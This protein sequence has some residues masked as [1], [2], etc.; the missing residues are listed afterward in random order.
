MNSE[1]IRTHLKVV[2]WINIVVGILFVLSAISFASYVFFI[3]PHDGKNSPDGLGWGSLIA[4]FGL[5]CSPLGLLPILTGRYLLQYRLWTHTASIILSALY[6]LSGYLII[7]G[8]YNL[9][10]LL[11]PE[12]KY[13]FE[14]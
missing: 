14:E 11:H 6:I 1:N 5:I 10:V 3:A 8:I 7:L 12:S 4:I 2:A 13:P 9:V